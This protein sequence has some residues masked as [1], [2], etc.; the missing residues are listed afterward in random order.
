MLIMISSHPENGSKHNYNAI[1]FAATPGSSLL[2]NI[3]VK[4]IEWH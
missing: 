2:T 4:F 3:G 1:Q